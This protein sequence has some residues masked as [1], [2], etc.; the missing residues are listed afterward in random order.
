MKF[1][2]YI[3]KDGLTVKFKDEQFIFKKNGK[4]SYLY[5]RKQKNKIV[6]STIFSSEK[7]QVDVAIYPIRPIQMP[8]QIAHNIMIKLDPPIAIHPNSKVIHY[9]TMPI[10][11]GIFTICKKSNYMIDAFSLSFPKYGLYGNPDLGYICRLHNSFISS[12]A[13]SKKYEEAIIIMKF[14]NKNQNWVTVNKIVMDAYMV[15]LYIKDDVV[16]LED[17]EM[18]IGIDNVAS[19]FLNN[20]SPLRGLKEVPVAAETVKK[21]RRGILERTGFGVKGKFIMEY[22]Y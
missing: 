8:K 13:K 19:L 12:E 20:K 15:D 14:E 17:S 3:L 10:E 2:K 21:F 5:Q 7:D 9:L 11:I 18:V 1:G 4:D 22:G 16:Y 6:A